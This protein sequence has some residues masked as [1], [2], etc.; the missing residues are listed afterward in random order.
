MTPPTNQET[1]P[2]QA[3]CA[4]CPAFMHSMAEVTDWVPPP[5]TTR[6]LWEYRCPKG[7]LTYKPGPLRQGSEA[8]A[9][10]LIP[11]DK[12]PPKKEKPPGDM[13]SQGA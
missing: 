10:T 7:H 6:N 12:M 8:E 13:R 3:L 9:P 5:G 2:H 11:E 1:D 4:T